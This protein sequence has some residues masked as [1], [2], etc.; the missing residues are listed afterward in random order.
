MYTVCRDTGGEEKKE[1]KNLFS[2]NKKYNINLNWYEHVNKTSYNN[3]PS[4][5]PQYMRCVP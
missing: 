2:N 1:K 4:D 5:L 3:G